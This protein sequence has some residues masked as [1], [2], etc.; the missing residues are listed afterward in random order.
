MTNVMINSSQTI[1]KEISRATTM[2][3][4]VCTK[5]GSSD[6]LELQEVAMPKVKENQVLIKVH[7]TIV[8]RAD[9][10]MRTGYPLFGRLFMGLFKP[11][12]P[13]AG[14]G[15]AGTIVAIG[16]NVTQFKVGHEIF[17][18]TILSFGANAEYVTMNETEVLAL[19]P[20]NIS[21]QEAA[22]VC[23]GAL[24]SIN[25]LK[26]IAKIQ[27]GQRIL[28]NG[29]SGSLGT[30]AVQLAKHYGAHVTGVCS[31]A[32]IELVK[33]LGAD[34]VID[35]KK[36]DFTKAGLAYDVIYDTV[37]LSSFSKCKKSLTKNGAFVS[38]VL[39]MPLLFQMLWT[40]IF[41]SKKAKFSATGI[42]PIPELK[43]LLDELIEII[44]A[45]KLKT[46]IDKRYLLEQ[47]PQAHSYVDKGHKK[48]NIVIDLN[49]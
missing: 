4:I 25:F 23:D 34:E 2:K 11:K 44:N 13:I 37:G 22:P 12:N 41:G 7:A 27:P 17:G 35:Y 48:G 43:V 42:L 32:N 24:T 1:T 28:I 20:S 30:A 29:A 39:G 31:T 3:A 40:S 8:T 21:H 14:T 26:N 46:I 45:G 19:K 49:R 47:V 9:T 38:P 15:V 18:E 16:N 5:Y 10:M 6:V 33:S 36:E